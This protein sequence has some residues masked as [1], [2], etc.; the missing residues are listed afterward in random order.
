MLNLMCLQITK[1]YKTSQT[2]SWIY[3][4]GLGET[5]ERIGRK[6]RPERERK[7]SSAKRHLQLREVRKNQLN[8]FLRRR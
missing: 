6:R 4:M 1:K 8:K 2:G 7:M 5:L 3:R